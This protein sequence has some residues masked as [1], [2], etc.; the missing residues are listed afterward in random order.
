MQQLTLQFE[1]FADEIRQPIDVSTTK[2]CTVESHQSW[3][4]AENSLFSQIAGVSLSN[5]Q[6]LQGSAAVA[7]SF[8]FMFFAAMIGG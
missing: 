3:L 8:A 5:L 2:Q 7:L 6:A 1:G 4:Q